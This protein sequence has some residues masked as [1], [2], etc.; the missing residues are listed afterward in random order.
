[1]D[2]R[3]LQE[4][5][6]AAGRQA[7]DHGLAKA[8]SGNISARLPGA[9]EFWIT[10]SGTDLSALTPDLL[11]RMGLDGQPRSQAHPPSS[12]YQLH[13]A[14]Y[15]RRPEINA[16]V[17]LHPPLA[18]VVGTALGEVEPVTFEGCYFLGDV[19]IVP[20]ILPGTAELAQAAAEATDRSR[21]LVLQHHGSVCLGV[22]L[23]EA[24]Y[25]SIELE[26]TC[27][28]IVIARALGHD[29]SLPRW[30]IERMRGRRY[31]EASP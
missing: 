24:L 3:T 7:A 1:M 14:I 25:R 9:E 21:V 26:E 2:E 23:Q 19:A 8:T 31:K 11:V 16:I 10:A 18:T 27:R 15:R 20:P 12:E 17:H 30:A 22:D 29:L 5:I 4:Q 6:C 13:L 28:L